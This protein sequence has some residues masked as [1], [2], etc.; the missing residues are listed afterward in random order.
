[1][2]SNS[3]KYLKLTS[4]AKRAI[5]NKD[6]AIEHESERISTHHYCSQYFQWVQVLPLDSGVPL[7]FMIYVVYFLL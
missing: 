7:F 1:M 2:T 3:E 6:D 5:K 4:L